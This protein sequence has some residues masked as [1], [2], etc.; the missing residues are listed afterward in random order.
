MDNQSVGQPASQPGWQVD[1]ES[2]S[3]P[4]SSNDSLL[5][6]AHTRR[7]LFQAG[8]SSRFIGIWLAGWLA[9]SSLK[10]TGWPAFAFTDNQTHG[11]HC[12]VA[13]PTA[14]WLPPT[15]EHLCV[16]VCVQKTTNCLLWLAM[17]EG[18]TFCR[19]P[20]QLNLAGNLSLWH[21]SY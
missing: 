4:T 13:L 12:R 10:P 5:C 3:S 2:D 15:T 18:R 6:D 16:C 9:C 17:I 14:T 20:F 1:I 21:Q 8:P 11:S 7:I 19:L